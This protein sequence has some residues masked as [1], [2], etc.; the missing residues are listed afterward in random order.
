[1]LSTFPESTVLFTNQFAVVQSELRG[2]TNTAVSWTITTNPANAGMLTGGSSNRHAV[3]SAKAAGTYVLTATSVADRTKKSSATIYVTAH[4]LPSPNADHTEAIDCTG[5]GNGKVY[6][7]GPARAFKDLNA[8]PWLS[9]KGGDTVRIHNDDHT[10]GA[11]TTYHQHVAIAASGT[12]TQ[13]LR[14]CGVPDEKGIKP[15]IDGADATTRTDENWAGGWVENLALLLLY[16]GD[17][18]WGAALQQNRNVIVEGLHLRNARPAF[19]IIKAGSPKPVPYDGSAACVMVQTG[20]GILIRGNELENCSQGIFTNAR[21]PGGAMV[22]DLTVQGNWLHD[23][24]GADNFLV[25]AMY[26]QAIGMQVQFNYI[27]ASVPRAL[28]N[29]IK[30]RSVQNF[31]RWN[32]VSQPV[33]TT[34]RAFDLVE[35]QAFVCYV[36][37]RDFAFVYHGGGE[38]S[39]CYPPNPGPAADTIT[40][41]QI[42]ANYESYFSDYIYGNIMDDTGTEVPFVHYGYDQ[43]TAAGPA[44]NRRGGTLYY[45]NNTHLTHRKSGEK[46][47]FDPIAPD[48]GHSYSYPKI[49]SLNNVFLGGPEV[50]FLW[51]RAFWPEISIDSSWVYPAYS[52][53]SRSSS[54]SYQG[55]TPRSQQ[56]GCDGYGMCKANQGHLTW[57]R[58]GVPAPASSAVHI[59]PRAFDPQTFRPEDALRGLAAPLPRGIEDQPSN[60]EYFPATNEIQ[61]R[62]DL[63]FLGALDRP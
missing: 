33:I 47:I 61:P 44:F 12:A 9:L 55:G 17:H 42:A 56:S 16:D 32:Y 46:W 6:E 39:D 41:D 13:P 20:I 49:S 7:V 43:Q 38:P 53:P 26:L 59:G 15:V 18:K 36:I 2:S 63:S 48:V 34:A 35:P 27:G 22:Y 11:P 62:R 8:I 51:T 24:G 3:F 57:L 45:W 25:H 54:D 50:S 37:P 10:G 29:A 19:G 21:T 1:M 58:A 60:M 30:S 4:P 31:L 40:A 52:L 14:I 28:G 5:V 23:W